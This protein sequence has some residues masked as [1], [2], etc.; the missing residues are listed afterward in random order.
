MVAVIIFVGLYL[1]VALAFLYAAW[2]APLFGIPV[3][4]IWLVLGWA[5]DQSTKYRADD[6]LWPNDPIRPGTSEWNKFIKKQ[7]KLEGRAKKK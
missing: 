1:M 4:L 6:L 2:Q 5:F 7:R 3:L